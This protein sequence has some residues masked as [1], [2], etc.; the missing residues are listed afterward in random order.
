MAG[1]SCGHKVR[2]SFF[3]HF[4]YDKMQP[5]KVSGGEKT[6]SCPKIVWP[7]VADATHF[8]KTTAVDLKIGSLWRAPFELA[9]DAKLTYLL[10]CI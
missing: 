6:V 1:N 9:V 10:H 2:A 8:S 5:M 3:F 4:Y 7:K